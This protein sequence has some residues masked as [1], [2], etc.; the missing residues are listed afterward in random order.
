MR[1]MCH[2]RPAGETRWVQRGRD[3]YPGR[4]RPGLILA[5]ALFGGEGVARLAGLTGGGGAIMPGE[6]VEA[7]YSPLFRRGWP[8][9]WS[10][11]ILVGLGLAVFISPLG[12]LAMMVVFGALLI[13]TLRRLADPRPVIVIGPEGFHDRR[14]GRPIP[15]AG[16]RDLRRHK[17]G[18]RIFLQIGVDDP[19]AYLGNAGMLAGPMLRINPAMGFAALSSNLAGL[20]VPQVALAATAEGW[21]AATQAGS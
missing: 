17:A 16:I 21:M 19:K 8:L 3:F 7:H 12:G 2:I 14:L 6:R 20:T 13:L 9:F 10:A 18:S 5:G 11:W 15:W 4:G 1:L